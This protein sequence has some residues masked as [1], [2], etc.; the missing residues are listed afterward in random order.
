MN[1]VKPKNQ[2]NRYNVVAVLCLIF[3]S[4]LIIR[5]FQKQVVQ[6]AEYTEIAKKQYT[7]IEDVY[8]SRGKIYI[9]D[10]WEKEP[11]AVATNIHLYSVQ[12]IPKNIQD[13]L[14][15]AQKLSSVLKINE[16][17][18]YE[19]I[20][21]KKPYLPPIVKKLDKETAKKIADFELTGV[22]LIPE[23]Q[24]VYPEGNFLSNLLGFV[25]ASQNGRYGV[26]NFYNEE[27]K[28]KYGK[29]ISSKIGLEGITLEQ[30]INSQDGQNLY[31]T[32]DHT[33]QYICE[34]YL[35]DAINQYKAASGQVAIA[36]ASTGKILAM[37]SSENYDPNKFN[38]V[39][40]INKFNNPVISYS[41][42]P[43]SIFKPITMAAAIDAGKIEPDTTQVFGASVKVH[44]RT[45]KTSTNKAYGKET[46]TQVLEN[47]DNVA[48][49][50]VADQLGSDL[51]SQYLQNF[52][53]GK[54]TGIDLEAEADVWFPD[55][56]KISDVSRATMSFGQGIATTPIQ[57]LNSY[58]AL[59][60][61]G[62][63]MQPYVVDKIISEN[64]ETIQNNPI[65]V[66]QVIKPETANK[67]TGML[68]SVVENGHGKKAGV[69]GYKVAG[70]TGTAQ[71][72][73]LVNGGYKEHENIGSFAGYFPANNPKFVM[74]V[75]I[76][77]PKTVTWA[78]ESAAPVFGKIAKWLLQYYQIPP[79][80]SVE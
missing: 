43:G 11:F 12:V 50:W 27:L 75:K 38:E 60:N 13:P 74:L 14:Q 4:I 66:K 25:D 55:N 79:T 32:I 8:A 44:D 5:L 18:L 70:K 28:G 57:I 56:N 24:R 16:K 78:E 21:N 26:E 7:E 46:M 41:Y 45:I 37:A 39:K 49:V 3:C 63:L 67:I 69:K 22:M 51:F 53:F 10:K 80:E 52:G 71:V 40:D 58:I 20:N 15:T 61:N 19:K 73:D 31:L 68:I 47:S 64:D 72:P 59:A 62:K 76:D 6:S 34:K 2:I 54:K 23:E 30:V 29:N 35:Q 42:E 9:T 17:E 33:V 48:M 65:E 36:E 1:F 77:N